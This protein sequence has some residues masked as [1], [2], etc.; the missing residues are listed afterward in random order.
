MLSVEDDGVGI[1][2]KEA[3]FQLFGEGEA[4]MTRSA[5]G[6]GIGLY[7]A[8]TLCDEFGFKLSFEDAKT[9]SG[10]RFCISGK[11]TNHEA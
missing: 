7:Y 11:I 10:T 2:N 1:K 4:E 3:I 5:K 8:K 9:L 6:T